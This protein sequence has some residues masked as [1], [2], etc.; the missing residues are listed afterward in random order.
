MKVKPKMD[1]LEA[2]MPGEMQNS[3]EVMCNEERV[4]SNEY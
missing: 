3:S 1:V 4:M 2:E